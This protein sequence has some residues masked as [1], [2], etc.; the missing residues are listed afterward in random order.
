MQK[1]I[2]LNY[3]RY[4]VLEV[5]EKKY[6]VDMFT[7][8]WAIPLCGFN[9]FLKR[10][11]YYIEDESVLNSIIM[12]QQSSVLNKLVPAILLTSSL[13]IRRIIGY[14][15][16][17]ISIDTITLMNVII[18]VIACFIFILILHKDLKHLEKTIN[19]N[20][21]EGVYVYRS[22]KNK[23]NVKLFIQ[24][25]FITIIIFGGSLLAFALT[26]LAPNVLCF[27]VYAVTLYVYLI[28]SLGLGM[29]KENS[30]IVI[31]ENGDKSMI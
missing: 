1:I 26:Y 25:I 20:A 5:D 8:K 31:R 15:D 29:I 24:V 2:G 18:T 30:F 10:K 3:L 16:L 6:V 14:F 11:A 21:S 17:T 28:F 19:L 23:D 12:K 9:I 4:Q 27:V 7:N 13:L 22:L